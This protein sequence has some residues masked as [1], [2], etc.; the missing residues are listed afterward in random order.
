MIAAPPGPEAAMRLVAALM[1]LLGA[2]V[3]AAARGGGAAWW[4]AWPV[5]LVALLSPLGR[6]ALDQVMIEPLCAALMFWCAM[7]Y[8]RYLA[9]GAMGA[10]IRFGIWSGVAL[11]VKPNAA[12]LA[13]LPPLAVALGRRWDLLRRPSFWIP[14]PIVAA[15]AG[16]W[17]AWSW[18][19]LENEWIPGGKE[20]YLS[21]AAL[22][23]WET[24][25][26][27][28]ALAYT[29]IA[30]GVAGWIAMRAKAPGRSAAFASLALAVLLT[31]MV[32]S[33]HLDPRHYL[34]AIGPALAGAGWALARLPLAAAGAVAVASIALAGNPALAPKLDT[35]MDEA[36]GFLAGR[37]GVWLVS[38]DS[39]GEGAF[40]TAVALR[41]RR[42][43]SF[44]LRANK[45]L[46]DQS[47]MGLQYRPL[48]SSADKLSGA[49]ERWP[50]NAIVVD[51][52]PRVREPHNR[53]L[54]D[55]LKKPGPAQWRIA[56][57]AGQVAVWVR[58]GTAPPLTGAFRRELAERLQIAWR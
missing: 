17:Y 50:V 56:H 23:I 43:S 51:Q 7:H 4:I 15:M 28:G 21:R 31:H 18:R 16:P 34:L 9:S 33:P 41:E 12:A 47:W 40:L 20:S 24:P 22:V 25:W 2:M 30:L 3:F 32:I 49:L 6:N 38:S 48:Y 27:G 36:A 45:M 37:S 10:A 26:L 11:L 53:L 8:S 5:G 19:W 46:A 1:A 55:A 57:Q 42:P 14:A 52:S 58:E 39:S 35:G 29:V 54:H 44:V 13:L